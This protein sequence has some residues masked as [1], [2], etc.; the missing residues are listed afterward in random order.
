MPNELAMFT[1]ADELARELMNERHMKTKPPR[2]IK[3]R[4]H[5]RA[6]KFLE[7]VKIKVVRL[8]AISAS[9]VALATSFCRRPKIR[10]KNRA[11]CPRVLA[12]DL[13]ALSRER[14]QDNCAL[15]QD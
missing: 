2:L 1:A 4:R 15:P 11:E 3:T 6:Q 12:V 10:Q 5:R 14:H 8:D 13:A 9:F 7:L